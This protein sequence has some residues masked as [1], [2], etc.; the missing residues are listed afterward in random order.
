MGR[1]RRRGRRARWLVGVPQ[2]RGDHPSLPLRE[3]CV[4]DAGLAA[5]ERNATLALRNE[6][7]LRANDL[8]HGPIRFAVT[9]CSWWWPGCPARE[10]AEGTHVTLDLSYQLLDGGTGTHDVGLSYRVD[11]GPVSMTGSG[12]VAADRS[13][14]SRGPSHWR[15]RKTSVVWTTWSSSSSSTLDPRSGPARPATLVVVAPDECPAKYYDQLA[16]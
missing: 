3:A 8:A 4:S 1:P 12:D 15:W 6:R 13:A 7:Q 2:P 16:R 14:T 9:T 10:L 5:F 11:D